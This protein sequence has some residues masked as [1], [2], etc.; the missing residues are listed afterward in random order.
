MPAGYLP[1]R[2]H[3]QEERSAAV[4]EAVAGLPLQ[5][6]TAVV[7]R[8]NGLDMA[9]IARTMGV[10]EGTVKAQLH[11]ARAKLSATMEKT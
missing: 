11:A 10:A 5:Q 3:L 1:E 9:E 6:R 7:L 8:S 2:I 4:R